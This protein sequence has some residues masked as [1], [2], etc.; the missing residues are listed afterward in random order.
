MKHE[1]I[2]IIPCIKKPDIQIIVKY[3]KE[4]IKYGN[5]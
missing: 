5:L 4:M 3:V 2:N 1:M